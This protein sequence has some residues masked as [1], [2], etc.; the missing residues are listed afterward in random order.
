MPSSRH[1]H[2]HQHRGVS[3]GPPRARAAGARIV[4]YPQR[5]PSL[6]LESGLDIGAMDE[7]KPDTGRSSGGPLKPAAAA[8][9]A[10]A[11]TPAALPTDVPPTLVPTGQHLSVS[12]RSLIVVA[13]SATACR[14]SPLA[15]ATMPLSFS[16]LFSSIPNFSA[17][18]IAMSLPGVGIV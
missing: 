15:Y 16:T 4:T 2:K 12:I 7:E 11:A 13:S 6:D 10:A 14:P 9:A 17:Q 3:A 18:D 5:V 1:W 8:A